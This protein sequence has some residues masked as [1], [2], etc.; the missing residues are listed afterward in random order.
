MAYQCWSCEG[1]TFPKKDELRT[2]YLNKPHTF[3]EVVCPFCT[4]KR[5]TIRRP[6]DLR[7]HI[8]E[9]HRDIFKTQGKGFPTDAE[10]FFLSPS[11]RAYL[12]CLPTTP[13]EN[14]RTSILR[15]AVLANPMLRPQDNWQ[16]GWDRHL[17]TKPILPYSPMTPAL[18]TL[19]TMTLDPVEGKLIVVGGDDSILRL[20]VPLHQQKTRERLMR[21]LVT[22]KPGMDTP[23][24]W[25]KTT[26][27]DMTT[28]L[29]VIGL[30][31]IPVGLVERTAWPEA[32]APKRQRQMPAPL[33][34]LPAL[35]DEPTVDEPPPT[36]PDNLELPSTS[37]AKETPAVPTEADCAQTDPTGLPG[38]KADTLPMPS[39]EAE[40][41][42]TY[43]DPVGSL[44][45]TQDRRIVKEGSGKKRKATQV[46]SV[47]PPGPEDNGRIEHAQRLLLLGGMPLFPPAG[48]DWKAEE[49]VPLPLGCPLGM[50]PPSGWQG[51]SA[52]SRLLIWET[53]STVLAMKWDMP[54]D[55]S[56][57]LDAF[58]FLALP[59]TRD[60]PL[61]TSE[62]RMR[63]G[64]FTCLRKIAMD[65]PVGESNYLLQMFGTAFIASLSSQEGPYRDFIVSTACVPMRLR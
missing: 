43:V 50:W 35:A 46:V 9:R 20:H 21:R 41:Q 32:P 64:N 34:P 13:Q 53:T 22:V 57:I 51:M 58:Q 10:A 38:A 4:Y 27:Q 5:N 65:Q 7:T 56:F 14:A 37:P 63:H 8:K 18:W 45:K 60:P 28:I 47:P 44:Q 55:R 24:K 6:V 54:L 40:A 26:R 59:G 48:W 61:E 39:S 52:D 2:H 31:G 36:S 49:Q 23:D 19:E 16:K 3:M 62:A 15:E 17:P 11:P 25:E 42:S 30:E 1:V 12:N 29:T 33:S